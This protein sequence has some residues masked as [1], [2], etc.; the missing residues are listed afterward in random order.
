VGFFGCSGAGVEMTGKFMAR[1]SK[2][3]EYI[4]AGDKPWQAE[5][6][7]TVKTARHMLSQVSYKQDMMRLGECRQTVVVLMRCFFGCWEWGYIG[8]S[9]TL[10]L[11]CLADA[12][13]LSERS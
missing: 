4:D 6:A 9:V 11:C 7:D 10:F 3:G 12:S 5:G 2:L 8:G 13:N 1:V